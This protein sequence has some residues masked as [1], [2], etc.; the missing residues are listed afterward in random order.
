MREL[1]YINRIEQQLIH[2]I[3]TEM[4]KQMCQSAVHLRD[5]LK[6]HYAEAM[7]YSRPFSLKLGVCKEKEFRLFKDYVLDLAME[8]GIVF[9]NMS[10]YFDDL[11]QYAAM[12]IKYRMCSVT[13]KPHDPDNGYVVEIHHV[14]K[15]GMGN[16][17]TQVDHSKLRRMAL[18][19]EY[20]Q[21]THAMGEISFQEKYHVV[22]VCTKYR[23]KGH[24]LLD[25][26]IDVKKQEE[27]NVWMEEK[28]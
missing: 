22:G 9:E 19:S 7:D 2:A 16:D 21:L 4:A 25:D 28:I 17:R 23:S 26:E 8:Y 5:Q 11:E 3:I 15:V 20:H 27:Q 18:L 6:Q 24:L 10:T 13:L 14:D 12:C 1:T